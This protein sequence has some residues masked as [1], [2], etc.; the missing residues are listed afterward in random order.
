MATSGYSAR[1]AEWL[2]PTPET[3]VRHTAV[4]LHVDPDPDPDPSGPL[5]SEEIEKLTA[6]ARRNPLQFGL[7][8]DQVTRIG[9]AVDWAIR[10]FG[11]DDLRIRMDMDPQSQRDRNDFHWKTGLGLR[12]SL[13]KYFEYNQWDP[14][15]FGL[16]KGSTLEQVDEGALMR[17]GDAVSR[18]IVVSDPFVTWGAT[19]DELN[20]LVGSTRAKALVV[21]RV[22]RLS[23]PDGCYGTRPERGTT[24][25]PQLFSE[26]ILCKVSA[27]KA[28]ATTTGEEVSAATKLFLFG[29][30]PDP[31]ERKSGILSQ[32]II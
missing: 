19:W 4:S 10:K 9:W 3:K 13:R 26:R 15:R 5:T 23:T 1:F 7:C 32:Y 18:S 27:L 14:A 20:R 8:P 6:F 17:V 16:P 11:S 21:D 12:C 30:L 22:K 2:F 24:G 31:E 28:K 29:K 25:G